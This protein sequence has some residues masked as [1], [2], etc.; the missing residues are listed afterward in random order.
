MSGIDWLVAIIIVAGIGG[1]IASWK[2]DAHW[3][4][5]ISRMRKRQ[6]ELLDELAEM[7]LGRIEESQRASREREEALRSLMERVVKAVEDKK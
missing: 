2:A 4:R 3:D 5:E 6:D 7:E 1:V